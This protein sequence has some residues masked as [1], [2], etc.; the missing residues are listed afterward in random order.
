MELT[1]AAFHSQH[2]RFSK[3]P[4]EFEICRRAAAHA[5]RFLR[6]GL[7]RQPLSAGAA[8]PRVAGQRIGPTAT[9]LKPRGREHGEAR[10]PPD[11]IGARHPRAILVGFSGREAALSY[12]RALHRRPPSAFAP[13]IRHHRH[14]AKAKRPTARRGAEP[15]DLIGARHPR[16]ILVD[17]SGEEAAFCYCWPLR[18]RLR[19]PSR[20][21]PQQP[22]VAHHEA[23]RLVGS[24]MAQPPSEDK[25]E[26]SS[27]ARSPCKGPQWPSATLPLK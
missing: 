20:R 2:N 12:D 11:L 16:A 8:G 21:S 27:L 3:D 4:A 13:V 22:R 23:G 7:H 19:A 24:A 1:P 9:L 26:T 25:D 15:P 5:R 6:P 18:R 17:P 14:V 10:E